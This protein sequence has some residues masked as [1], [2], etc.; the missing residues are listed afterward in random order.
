[1]HGLSIRVGDTCP[2]PALSIGIGYFP[3]VRVL[4]GCRPPQGVRRDLRLRQ[5]VLHK[6]QLAQRVVGQ[7]HFPPVRVLDPGQVPL[8]CVG[9]LC[10]EALLVQL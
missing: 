1:M 5:P 6:G 8:L 9:I 2:L 7:L 4:Y 3:A 10:Q